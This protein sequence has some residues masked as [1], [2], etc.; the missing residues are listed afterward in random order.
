MGHTHAQIEK[1]MKYG[2]I[3]SDGST[4]S[5]CNTFEVAV[6]PDATRQVAS[7]PTTLCSEK[8]KIAEQRKYQR[9]GIV[10]L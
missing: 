4:T 1:Q 2:N 9:F 8:L 10:F 6:V 3:P 5:S 7:V